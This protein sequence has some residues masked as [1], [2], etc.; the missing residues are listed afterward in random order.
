MKNVKFST[1]TPHSQT[2]NLSA[3]AL[4]KRRKFRATFKITKEKLSKKDITSILKAMNSKNGKLNL[5]ETAKKILHDLDKKKQG[6]VETNDLIE[7]LI[8]KETEED[9][10][11]DIYNT[12][13]AVLHTK[14]EDIIKKLK[15]LQNKT[16]ISNSN[17]YVDSIDFIIKTITEENLYEFDTTDFKQQVGND[18]HSGI[19][20]LVKYSQIE[21]SKRKE[22][23][24]SGVRKR[25]KVYSKES[26]LH[27]MM[28]SAKNR[29]HNKKRRSTNLTTMISPSII[30]TIH[31]QIAKIDQCD[32]NIFEL[33]NLLDKKA[34]I[35]VATEILSR[36]DIV[37][38]S[39]IEEQTLKNFINEIT[40]HYDRVNAIY[41]N[42]LHAADVMQTTFTVFVRGDIQQVSIKY[43]YIFIHVNRK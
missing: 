42:D 33:D 3:E 21:D 40:E 35:Y 19:D 23:D 7:K 41:H 27:N 30:A 31:N 18:T 38:S 2:K 25:S 26:S 39:Y 34:S 22:E 10:F 8:S 28:A 4:S 17:I 5:E 32:F 12:I 6:Y 16:W 14:S 9:D 1:D 20:Y 15:R 37:E 13:N 43:I 24:F 36:F 29:D 11:T